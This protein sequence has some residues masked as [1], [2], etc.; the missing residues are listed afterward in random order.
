MFDKRY[1]AQV[2]L[3]IR[4]LPV[5]SRYSCFALKGGTAI[6][7]FIRDLPRISVDIDLTYLPLK[8]RDDA[9]VEISD[10][11]QLIGNDIKHILPG[12]LV[13]VSRNRGYAIRLQ[14]SAT[15]AVIKVEPNLILRGAVHPF[16]NIDLCQAAQAQFGAFVSVPV[17]SIADLYGGKLCAALDRQHPRDLFDVKLLLNE[18]GITPEI[19]RSFVVYLASHNRPMNELLSPN[20]LDIRSLY[21]E[22]FRGMTLEEVPLHELQH[23]QGELP[24]ML[25]RSLDEDER[26]FLLSM[27]RGE[28][29]WGRLGIENL[30]RFPA[31][32]WKLL[33]ISRMTPAKRDAGFNRL[34]GILS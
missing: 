13:R 4:C 23:L 22:Q 10:T 25:V 20:P 16:Q 30:D 24:R 27:K 21:E 34:R 6:N 28:P 5:I 14:I 19:R 1:E 3:L 29:E 2:R 17:L 15:D 7:L 33:N 8:P 11:L 9:L 31:L 32:Q 26:A 18:T 12:A